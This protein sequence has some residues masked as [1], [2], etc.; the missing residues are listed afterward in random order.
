MDSLLHAPPP[1]FP[2]LSASATDYQADLL[3]A[4]VEHTA[5]ANSLWAPVWN[6]EGALVDFRYLY[7]NPAAARYLGYT[8]GELTGKL[9]SEINKSF[10]ESGHADLFANVYT[11]G[12]AIRQE[13]L[14]PS[15][16]RWLDIS[17]SRVGDVLLMSFY[18]IHE[19]HEATI[20]LQEQAALLQRVVDH[21]PSGMMLLQ[22]VR[23]ETNTIVD[24]K[25]LL[26]NEL[27]AK[28]TGYTVEQ[29]TG[30]LISALF[31]DY[32][33]L[34][35]FETLV[36]VTEQGESVEN[37]FTYDQYGVQ[38]TFEGYYVKQGDGVLFTFVNITRLSEQQQQLTQ[39]NRELLQSNE[40]LQQFAYIASHDLQE[41]LRKVQSFSKMLGEQY[42][43][44]LEGTGLDMLTRVQSSARRMSD[45]IRDLLNYSRLT[46]EKEPFVSVDL[47]DIISEAFTDLEVRIQE[48]QP[49]IQVDSLPTVQGRAVQLRQLFHNLLGNALKFQPPGQKPMIAVTCQLADAATLPPDLSA[50]RAYWQIDVR[51]NGIGFNQQYTDRIFDVFQ[52]LHGKN[53]Y[54]GTGVGLAVC[55]RVAQTHGGSI[56]AVSRLD[57]GATF[58]VYLPK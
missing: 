17:V 39:M 21:S 48:T 43:D 6:K 16:H 32:Q 31:P 7:V 29:M 27:N 18:D 1:A 38:G 30:Q 12:N 2:V 5:C 9:V 33:A 34:D 11:S 44:Q 23:N 45:L 28:M 46:T 20:R 54:A 57:E 13:M 35:L 51:D 47:N 8:N 25:Y 36:Y 58:S 26:T 37:S 19:R 41:P 40:G 42:A 3:R 15:L 4:I 22:A 50:K 55:R 10:H 49:T 14:H 56:G 52:R 53:K 24:F